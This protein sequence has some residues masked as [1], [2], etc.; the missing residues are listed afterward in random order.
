VSDLALPD[1]R[2]Q[3]PGGLIRRWANDADVE[4]ITA[5]LGATLRRAQDENPSPRTMAGAR[6]LLGP[7]F[8]FMNGA[9]DAAIVEDPQAGGSIV[10]CTFFWRHTWSF[11]G[12]PFGVTRPELV[13]A[14][15]AY[16]RRGLIRAVFEM[17]HARGAAEGHLL[18]AITGIPYF[19]R[20]FGYEYALDLDGSRTAFFS[21]IPKAD[22]GQEEAC[23]L[24]PAVASDVEQLRAMYDA[25]HDDSLIRHEAG[26]QLWEWEISLWDDPSVR[27]G[28]ARTH[29]VDGRFWVIETA[30]GEPAGSAWIASHR[31]GSSL[32]V[33]ELFFAKGADVE[34]I[35]PSL[36][37][38]LRE[39]GADTPALREDTGPCNEIQL[40]LG[41]DH[42]IYGLLGADVAPGREDPYAW[43]VRV[44]DVP[45]FLRHV[46][47][48]LEARLEQSIFGASSST[49]EIDLYRG[50]LR[51][52]LDRGRLT[53]IEPW[54]APVPEEETTTMGC[55]PLTFLQLLLGHRSIEELVDIFPDVWIRPDRRLLVDTLFP[56]VPSRVEPLA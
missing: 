33:Q 14:D 45:A 32:R 12:I 6:L 36:L 43:L 24:R 10:A 52:V 47:P 39:I 44:P 23:R 20:Q 49:L 50:G 26:P 41:R 13:A 56:K 22:T 11:A 17:I 7:G 1:V 27:D 46:R 31:R 15:P 5:L 9:A 21:L 55:P 4:R 34:A 25:W 2:D 40:A 37:R 53:Q 28:D 35:A 16:R 30:A 18:S 38:G 29:G 48:A 8:P 3:L 54:N 42:P 19:Y 51:L